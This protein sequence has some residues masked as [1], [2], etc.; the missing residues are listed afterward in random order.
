MKALAAHKSQCML[1]NGSVPT[2]DTSDNTW[3]FWEGKTQYY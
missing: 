1:Q 2:I 3:R